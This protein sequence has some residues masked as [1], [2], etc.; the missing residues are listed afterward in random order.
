M[1]Q[2]LEKGFEKAMEKGGI[3]TRMLVSMKSGIPSAKAASMPDSEEHI[4]KLE[5]AIKEITGDAVK[6]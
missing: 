4:K 1:G 2:R 6:L 3:K 5:D